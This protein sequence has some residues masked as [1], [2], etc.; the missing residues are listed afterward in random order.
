MRPLYVAELLV[1]SVVFTPVAFSAE[2]FP[3]RPLR[4]IIPFPP[5]G[6]TDIIGRMVGHRLADAFGVQVVVDNRG[7]AA[8]IIGTELATRANPDGHT[9]MIGSV[10][11]LCINPSLHKN[12]SFDPTNPDI[13]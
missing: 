4:L 7:G 2:T 10:S 8:G 9:L 12:L 11:T 5:G 6:G 13:S 3:A 1:A